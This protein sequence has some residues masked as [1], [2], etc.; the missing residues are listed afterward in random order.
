MLA[1]GYRTGTVNRHICTL[2]AVFRLMRRMGRT[3]WDLADVHNLR[4]DN[5]L[6]DSPLTGIA[7]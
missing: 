5:S 6:K 3:D 4:A 2:R 1:V 7:A